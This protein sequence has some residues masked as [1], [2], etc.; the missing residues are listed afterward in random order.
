MNISF[1]KHGPLFIRDARSFECDVIRRA[2]F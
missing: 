1:G 2:Q